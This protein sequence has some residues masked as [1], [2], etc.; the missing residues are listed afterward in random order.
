MITYNHAPYIAQAIECVLA[1]KTNFPFELVIGE[2]CS[3][4]GTREIV[5]DYAKRYPDIIRVITSDNNVGMKANSYRTTQACQ[6]KY[7]AWCEGDDYWHHPKKLQKQVDILEA[8]P[9]YSLVCSDYDALNVTTGQIIKK[10]VNQKGCKV[11]SS[12][13]MGDFLAQHGGNEGCIIG[14]S[15]RTSTAMGRSN[16]IKQLIADDPYLYQS[17][18][19][20]M[21]DTQL[22]AEMNLMG[23]IFF[24][25]ESLTTYSVLPDSASQSLNMSKK[26]RFII[27][28]LDLRLYLCDKYGVSS[29]V[30]RTHEINRLKMLLNLAF[31]EQD[32]TI[33][34]AVKDQKGLSGIKERLQY[35]GCKNCIV[36]CCYTIA[37]RVVKLLKT[38][39]E[40]WI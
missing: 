20:K 34:K 5:F 22:W 7:I 11:P 1:Q 32:K 17:D 30:R 10:I 23:E 21:G 19:F 26:L 14:C 31:Q 25:P 38:N 39:H 40:N 18:F 36:H 8:H 24:I 2:D 35:I 29:A 13:D 4:D 15:I 27:N 12:R 37:T 3:T 9:E 33:A 6:G 16:M 28:G